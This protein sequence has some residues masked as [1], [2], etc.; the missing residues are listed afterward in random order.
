MK[1]EITFTDERGFVEL[2]LGGKLRTLRFRTHELCMLEKRMGKGILSVLNEDGVG[3]EFLRDAIIVGVMHE[4]IGKRGKM[5]EALTEQKVCKWIDGC[6]EV[7]GI[8][9]EDLL[10]AVMVAVVGGLPGGKKMAADLRR[11]FEATEDDEGGE[12]NEETPVL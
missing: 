10:T 9:F 2:P 7:D 8:N 11:G 6:E 4:F 5:K 12:G 1:T 3:F